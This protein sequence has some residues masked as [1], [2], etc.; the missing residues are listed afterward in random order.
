MNPE[1]TLALTHILEKTVSA[2][3]NEREAAELYLEE[4]AQNNLPVF[5]KTLS[6][7]LHHGGNSQVARMAAGLHFKNTLTSKAQETKDVY[8]KRW[9]AFP[10]EIRTY[11]KNNVVGALGT[12]NNR[13]SSAAQCVA[14]IA[15][16]ELPAGQ[17]KELIPLLVQNVIGGTRDRKSVV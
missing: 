8:Q 1:A 4:A 14:Y 6:E 13:P 12:E 5:V 7:I 3:K 9:L 11:V 10:E 17:W 15:V 2:D 16:A